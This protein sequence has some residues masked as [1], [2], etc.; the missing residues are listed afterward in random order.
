MRARHGSLQD[1]VTLMKVIGPII[2]VVFIG[3]TFFFEVQD[4]LS[5]ISVLS[6]QMHIFNNIEAVITAFD[7]AA[8]F[9]MLTLMVSS[10]YLA[11]RIGAHPVFL[12]FSIIFGIFAI[13]ISAQLSNIWIKMAQTQPIAQYTSHFPLSEQLIIHFP[14]LLGVA[15]ILLVVVMYKSDPQRVR[16]GVR[17]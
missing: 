1:L 11:S 7:M 3:G 4:V 15:W 6:G 16:R 8:L 17:V 12:P 13:Y 5:G 10:L 9:V 14:K 2:L